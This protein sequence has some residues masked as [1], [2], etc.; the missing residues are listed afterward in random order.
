M[1]SKMNMARVGLQQVQ[2]QQ[3]NPILGLTEAMNFIHQ[4]I[5]G[6][7]SLEYPLR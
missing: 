2:R 4:K 5:N 3:Q 6:L 7:A 1:M